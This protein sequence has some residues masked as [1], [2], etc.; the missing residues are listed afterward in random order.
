MNT[1]VQNYSSVGFLAGTLFQRSREN[2]CSNLQ[3]EVDMIGT[4]PD[5]SERGLANGIALGMCIWVLLISLG[6][7][8]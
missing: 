6:M 3:I 1:V 7:A 4:N 8:L 5:S 2:R